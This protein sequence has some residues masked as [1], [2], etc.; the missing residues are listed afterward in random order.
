MCMC[1]VC[2]FM[3]CDDDDEESMQVSDDDE[4]AVKASSDDDEQ[5]IKASSDDDDDDDDVDNDSSSDS[6]SEK[7]PPP[8]PP[9]VNAP[10][11]R[12]LLKEQKRERANARYQ[13]YKAMAAWRT[14]LDEI[15]GENVKSTLFSDKDKMFEELN[16]IRK[17]VCSHQRLVDAITSSATY[18]LIDAEKAQLKKRGYDKEEATKV[19]WFNRRF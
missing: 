3:V 15:F 12:K 10:F 17:T 14:I 19:A 18:E 6:S 1:S 13:D 9:T 11:Y 8:K 5:A 2:V 4:Q 7:D 16:K